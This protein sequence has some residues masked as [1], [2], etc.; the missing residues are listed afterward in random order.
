MPICK[1]KS[2]LSIE[3]RL[4]L[5]FFHLV[6]VQKYFASYVWISFR[7]VWGRW[8]LFVQEGKLLGKYPIPPL[9]SMYNYGVSAGKRL[10]GAI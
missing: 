10:G 1:T 8:F 6:L 4:F 5:V 9:H 7:P 2:K 3:K